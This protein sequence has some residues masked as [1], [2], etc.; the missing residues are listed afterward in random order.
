MGRIWTFIRGNGANVGVEILINALAPFLIYTLTKHRLGDVN[1]LIA[2]SAPPLIWSLIEFAR[3]RRVDAISMIALAGIAFS[4]IGY[5][6]G[7]S[8]KLLQ[9]RE[10]LVTGAIGL[11]FLGSAAIGR[12]LIYQLA[13]ASMVRRQS[14]AQLAEFE[15]LKD[16]VHFRRT[17]R[18]LTLVWGF[19]LVAE[20]A[21]NVGLVFV[22]PIGA[23]LIIHPFIGYGTAGLLGGWSYL[24]VRAARRR[25]EE[26]RA[27]AQAAEQAATMPAEPG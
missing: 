3:H 21:V 13:R 18:V 25:G 14:Q 23:Y 26:H 22:I 15:A 24:Y 10:R 27:V 16:N 20:C 17:M 8:V 2:S 12:P 11:I 9:L 19:G 1:A 5:F 6:G 4:L 7:G